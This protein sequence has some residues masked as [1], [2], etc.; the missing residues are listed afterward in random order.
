M[1]TDTNKS[2]EY[3]LCSENVDRDWRLYVNADMSIY[4]IK[5]FKNDDVIFTAYG[6]V[7]SQSLDSMN[8]DQLVSLKWAQIQISAGK[9]RG[10]WLL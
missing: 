1:L 10:T 3:K 8:E 4:K 6:K 2:H 5:I 9:M 7:K